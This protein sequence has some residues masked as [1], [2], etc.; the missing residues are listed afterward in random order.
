MGYSRMVLS[1][2]STPSTS[3]PTWINIFLIFS[4]PEAESKVF[5][6]AS[7]APA[8]A[9]FTPG[10]SLPLRLLTVWP[11]SSIDTS[12]PNEPITGDAL[13]LLEVPLVGL[14]HLSLIHL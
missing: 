9:G 5:P 12:R 11:L 14:Q 8:L 13:P 4:R 10:S 1:H 6:S 3:R 7:N 2:I